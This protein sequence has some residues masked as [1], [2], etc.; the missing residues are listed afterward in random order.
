MK[1]IFARKGKIGEFED[2]IWKT[3]AEIG[4]ISTDTIF[5]SIKAFKE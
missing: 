4:R 2:N 1:K 5:L 3:V